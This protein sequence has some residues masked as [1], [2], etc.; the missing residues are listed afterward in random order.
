MIITRIGI[1]WDFNPIRW[2]F[3]A[4]S[5]STTSKGQLQTELLTS[6]SGST[7]DSTTSSRR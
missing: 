1:H 5:W 7:T 4:L 2:M 3:G 6:T